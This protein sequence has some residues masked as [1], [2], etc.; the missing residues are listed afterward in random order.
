MDCTHPEGY[1]FGCPDGEWVGRLDNKQWGN[2]KNLVLYFTNEDTGERFWLSVFWNNDYRPRDSQ[3][4]FRDEEAGSRYKM[5]TR[6]NEKGNPIFLGATKI[7]S[8]S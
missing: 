4:S 5:N 6:M 3:I 2:S 8:D 7:W 1:D